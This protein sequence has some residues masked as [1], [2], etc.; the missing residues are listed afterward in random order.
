MRA[1]HLDS[2]GGD[3]AAGHAGGPPAHTRVR[4]SRGRYAPRQ[5]PGMS[6]KKP[7]TAASSCG[8][9]R[10]GGLTSAWKLVAVAVCLQPLIETHPTTSITS[11]PPTGRIKAWG[12]DWLVLQKSFEEHRAGWLDRD[13]AGWLACNRPYP[14][15][16]E[17]LAGCEAPFYIASRCDHL[18][19]ARRPASPPACSRCCL[20]MQGLWRGGR[21]GCLATPQRLQS[22]HMSTRRAWPK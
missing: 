2:V 7:L 13:R 22:H 14:G 12:E 3:P 8:L 1:R 15:I 5:Q 9:W 19:T 21:A 16:V 18:S 10:I 6:C 4:G 17:A 20:K 11:N